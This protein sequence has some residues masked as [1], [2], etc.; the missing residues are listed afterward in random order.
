LAIHFEAKFDAL[1]Q[2]RTTD[3]RCMAAMADR[4]CA[5]GAGDMRQFSKTAWDIASQ[6]SNV[7][8][9]ETRDLAAQ[10]DDVLNKQ[11]QPIETAPRDEKIW[12]LANTQ[13][14]S[15]ATNDPFI[16]DVLRWFEGKWENGLSDHKYFPTHWQPLPEPPK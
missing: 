5:V 16:P 11:W 8:A 4:D 13:G 6:Y 10:I 12:I 7:L 1:A 2:D 3:A 9:S 15:P 14:L